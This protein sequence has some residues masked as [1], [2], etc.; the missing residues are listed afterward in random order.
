MSNVQNKILIASPVH[1]HLIEKLEA[2]DYV[3]IYEPAL[4]YE[5][6]KIKITDVEGLVVTTRLQIDK[7]IINAAENLKWIGSLTTPQ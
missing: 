5:D 7:T 1:P 2:N 6:L 4:I 3:V